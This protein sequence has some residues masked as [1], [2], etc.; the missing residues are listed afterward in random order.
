MLVTNPHFHFYN[1]KKICLKA[2]VCSN[3]MSLDLGSGSLKT[4]VFHTHSSDSQ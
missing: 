3:E 1:R 4:T 2:A